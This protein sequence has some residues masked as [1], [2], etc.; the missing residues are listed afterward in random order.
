VAANSR[1]RARA[2]G[3]PRQRSQNGC[4]PPHGVGSSQE[5]APGSSVLMPNSVRWP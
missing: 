3:S 4:R 1:A 2:L 5:H